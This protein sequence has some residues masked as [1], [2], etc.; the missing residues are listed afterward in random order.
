MGLINPDDV[1]ETIAEN[2][3]KSSFEQTFAALFRG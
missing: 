3:K 2:Q 1:M